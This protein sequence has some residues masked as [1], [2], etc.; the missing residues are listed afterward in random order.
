MTPTSLQFPQWE[1]FMPI[2][3]PS[4]LADVIEREY[5]LFDEHLDAIRARNW[6]KSWQ[7]LVELGRVKRQRLVL[8]PPPPRG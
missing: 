4:A 3:V 1:S 6:K 5:R 2:D 8:T 7:L